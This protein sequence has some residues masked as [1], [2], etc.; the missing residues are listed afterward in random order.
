MTVAGKGLTSAWNDECIALVEVL[1]LAN[2]DDDDSPLEGEFLQH[3]LML[4]EGA[5]KGCRTRQW[6]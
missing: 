5:L 2:E 1:L 6:G 4:G 3:H